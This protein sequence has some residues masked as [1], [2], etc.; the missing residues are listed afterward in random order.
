[1]RK[2]EELPLDIPKPVLRIENCHTVTEVRVN[3]NDGMGLSSVTAISKDCNSYPGNIFLRK[4]E[5]TEKEERCDGKKIFDLMIIAPQEG[6]KI[7]IL[8]EGEDANAKRQAL[9]L[10]SAFSSRYSFTL[11]FERFE[12]LMKREP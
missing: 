4:S 1:M 9:R 10:Y 6:T 3:L 2:Y 8:V 7:T 12:N 5:E 11:D